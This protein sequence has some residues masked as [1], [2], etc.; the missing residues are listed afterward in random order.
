MFLSL[1]KEVIL[2]VE[3]SI[4]GIPG[5][6]TGPSYLTIIIS[7]FSKF[8]GLFSSVSSSICSPLKTFALPTKTLFSNPPSTPA[9]FKIALYSGDKFPPNNL[10]P[11][12][13][14]NGFLTG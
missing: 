6:P 3:S 12:V 5:P 1:H 9:S 11:P 4:S 13:S 14:L 7:L 8:S 2:E 10:K